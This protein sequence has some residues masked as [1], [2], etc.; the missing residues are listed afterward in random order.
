[1]FT[2]DKVMKL[3]CTIDYFHIIFDVLIAQNSQPQQ[4]NTYSKYSPIVYR[5]AALK[6]F[7]KFTFRHHFNFITH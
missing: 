6:A 1:M 3:F 7:E 4:L 5:K 2:E